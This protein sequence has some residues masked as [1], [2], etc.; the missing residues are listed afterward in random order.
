M[1]LCNAA[2]NSVAELNNSTQHILADNLKEI[3]DSI[4]VSYLPLSNGGGLQI[5]GQIIGPTLLDRTVESAGIL[6]DLTSGSSPGW[7]PLKTRMLTI[8]S[9]HKV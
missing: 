3:A 5:L 1:Y 4:F 7:K 8:R 6:D 2:A 9:W